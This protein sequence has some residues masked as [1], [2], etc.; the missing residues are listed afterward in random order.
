MHP[1]NLNATEKPFFSGSIDP[2]NHSLNNISWNFGNGSEQDNASLSLPYTYEN[3]G[4]YT[5]LFTIIDFNN[6]SYTISIPLEVL[7][8]ELLDEQIIPNVITANGDQINDELNLDTAIDIC[9]EY[10]IIILNR[11][12]NKVFESKQFGPNFTGNDLDGSI[13]SEGVYFYII[14]ADSQERVGHIT[15]IK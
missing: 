15:I 5:A 13:L 3:A 12:G 9:L 1:C 8:N 14:R 10:E 11:W 2:N 7:N 6:C 4:T